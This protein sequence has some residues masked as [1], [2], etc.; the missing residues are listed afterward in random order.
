MAFP[1]RPCFT[2]NCQTN[3]YL[4]MAQLFSI[5]SLTPFKNLGFHRS[6]N[7]KIEENLDV[8]KLEKYRFEGKSE[9][10]GENIFYGR[11]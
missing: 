3:P 10:F 4:G 11:F 1:K 2:G 7:R 8:L 5:L 9:K 6:K